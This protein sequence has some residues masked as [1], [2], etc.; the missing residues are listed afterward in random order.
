[1]QELKNYIAIIPNEHADQFDIALHRI[2]HQSKIREGSRLKTII[3]SSRQTTYE[4]ALSEEEASVIALSCPGKYEYYTED[5]MSESI[6]EYV[7][8][9]FR[10]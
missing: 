7:N 3:P 8:G 9:T 6:N 10:S 2:S 4:V 1:M 5:R